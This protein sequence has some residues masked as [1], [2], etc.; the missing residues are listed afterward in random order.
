MQYLEAIESDLI[1]VTRLFGLED[2]MLTAETPRIAW[3]AWEDAGEYR[4]RCKCGDKAVQGAVAVP[5]EEADAAL[6]AMRASKYGADAAIIGEVSEGSKVRVRTGFGATR[7]M[8]MLV[9][10]Q[11]PR[12]C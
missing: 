7:I 12:I 8:D 9:G 3:Q 5:P 2:D 4:C 1:N 11:L 6:A 10:E